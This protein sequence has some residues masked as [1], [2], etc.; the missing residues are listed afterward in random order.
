MIGDRNSISQP[1]L[2]LR[3]SMR[4]QFGVE[5]E[6]EMTY[7]GRSAHSSSVGLTAGSTMPKEHFP[8]DEQVL[9]GV[10]S[11]VNGRTQR[12]RGCGKA[13]TYS[14]LDI[15]AGALPFLRRVMADGVGGCEVGGGG[16]GGGGCVTLCRLD[17][18]VV[19]GCS[20]DARGEPDTAGFLR[21]FV[22]GGMEV[23]VAGA[24]VEELDDAAWLAA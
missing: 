22:G 14:E 10:Y 23:D 6:G 2:L 16:S 15:V 5:G 17:R 4:I 21:F 13:E 24:A 11:K 20:G 12:E 3:D 1:T 7:L 19:D 9:R 8:V 18:R